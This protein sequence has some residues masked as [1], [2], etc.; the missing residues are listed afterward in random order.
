MPAPRTYTD[1]RD[2]EIAVSPLETEHNGV[3]GAASAQTEGAIRN[4]F[5][6]PK[7]EGRGAQE[8]LLR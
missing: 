7:E 3:Q 4:N 8:I 5:T 2:S 1:V 6:E